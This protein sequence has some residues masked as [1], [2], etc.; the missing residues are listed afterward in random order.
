MHPTLLPRHADLL[1]A[2][3]ETLIRLVPSLTLCSIQGVMVL[4]NMQIEEMLCRQV[5]LTL[6]APVHVRLLIVNLVVF[7]ACEVEAMVRWQCA[8]Y[9]VLRFG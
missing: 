3:D 5:S 2:L 7:V 9:F 4:G 8:A 6:Y 1:T